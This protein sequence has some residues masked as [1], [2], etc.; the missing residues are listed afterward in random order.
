MTPTYLKT[1]HAHLSSIFNHAIRYYDLSHNPAKKAGT[2][3]EEEDITLTAERTEITADGRDLCYV[4]IRVTDKDAAP[5][6]TSRAHISARVLGGEL[7]GC[8]S[9]DPKAKDPLPSGD[10][11]AFEGGAVAVVRTKQAGTLTLT[12]TALGKTHSVTLHAKDVL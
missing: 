4:T 1:I 5:V 7:L 12:V 11:D 3:G 8:F 9:G 10:C 2:M 6:P